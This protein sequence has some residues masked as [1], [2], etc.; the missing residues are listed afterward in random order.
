MKG[1]DTC[2]WLYVTQ[3]TIERL[4]LSTNLTMKQNE[5]YGLKTGKA[6]SCET[7]VGSYPVG[8]KFG[9]LRM[10][11]ELVIMLRQKLYFF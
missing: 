8:T 5:F 3:S 7:D 11:N 4:H 1:N 9:E 10:P 6:V 2:I